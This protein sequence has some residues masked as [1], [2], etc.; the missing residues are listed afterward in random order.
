MP[1][2]RRSR[3][4]SRPY[5]TV[6]VVSVPQRESITIRPSVSV[7]C[8]WLLISTLI[9]MSVSV[10]NVHT[11][12]SMEV[13][14]LLT[15]NPFGFATAL[16]LNGICGLFLNDHTTPNCT[17]MLHCIAWCSLA[18]VSRSHY[19]YIQCTV[20]FMESRLIF[21]KLLTACNEY[22]SVLLWLTQCL[23]SYSY[24]YPRGESINRKK[25]SP[26]C[27]GLESLHLMLADIH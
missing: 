22:K 18:L 26:F 20:T 21:V 3:P 27:A 2:S 1:V 8:V 10:S 7:R 14:L 23:E 13:R 24:M 12:F 5:S 15:N 17:I 4:L 25:G 9:L 6:T 16:H 19:F 11:S